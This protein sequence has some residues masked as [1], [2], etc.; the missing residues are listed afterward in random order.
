MNKCEKIAKAKRKKLTSAVD[1]VIDNAC[2]EMRKLSVMAD[3]LHKNAIKD[4]KRC[5]CSEGIKS[6]REWG[7]LE[8]YIQSRLIHLGLLADTTR[9]T[10]DFKE[11]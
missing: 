11:Q 1:K 4:N 7:S 2:R 10:K 8:V 9:G 3:K 5:G 6:R